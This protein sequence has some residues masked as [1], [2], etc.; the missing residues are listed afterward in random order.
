MG[1]VLICHR[2]P[3][4]SL[5]C[6]S[7]SWTFGWDHRCASCVASRPHRIILIPVSLSCFVVSFLSGK[8]EPGLDHTMR[9][10]WSRPSGR[11]SQSTAWTRM[12][13]QQNVL[14]IRKQWPRAL[15]VCERVDEAVCLPQ[16]S[17]RAA[18]FSSYG[19]TC[20]NCPIK[21]NTE[22]SCRSCSCSRKDLT[23][24]HH[25]AAIRKS[26]EDPRYRG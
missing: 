1:M 9:Q 6:G 16:P 19:L 26:R 23:R 3:F 7:A 21:W 8:M 18:T 11:R 4:M 22:G 2:S 25:A 20:P 24:R 10:C 15:H 13:G 12:N 14:G 17:G 5:R